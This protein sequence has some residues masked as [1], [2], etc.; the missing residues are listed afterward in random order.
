MVISYVVLFC[1]AVALEWHWIAEMEF[2]FGCSTA[3]PTNK[4]RVFDK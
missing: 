2:L 3:C 4:F 1:G